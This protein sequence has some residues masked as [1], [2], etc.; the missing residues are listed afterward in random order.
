M[1]ASV[2]LVLAVGSTTPDAVV[3]F[4][5]RLGV[6]TLKVVD[7]E[8]LHALDGGPFG[9]VNGETAR[10]Q[11]GGNRLGE[12][13]A[14]AGCGFDGHDEVM[15]LAVDKDGRVWATARLANGWLPWGNVSTE[16]AF[17]GKAVRVSCSSHG[18]ALCVTIREA[19]GTETKGVR[20]GDGRWA[21]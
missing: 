10:W 20:T 18:R 5:N 7:G 4:E 2:C 21:K 11:R 13:V 12:V 1:L 19:D 9:S 17:N 15:V 16:L 14:V 8:V 3:S 6:H